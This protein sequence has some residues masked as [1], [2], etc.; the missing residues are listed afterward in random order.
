MKN[1]KAI[2]IFGNLIF[3]FENLIFKISFTIG[4]KA[5]TLNIGFSCWKNQFLDLKIGFSGLKNQFLDLKNQ[6][7]D[8]KIGFSNQKI[9]LLKI[10]FS[11]QLFQKHNFENPVFQ[12]IFFKIIILKTQFSKHFFSKTLDYTLFFCIFFLQN[13]R[14]D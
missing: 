11:K 9:I 7:L 12:N 13:E 3:W 6:F 4:N 2:F 8:L 1:E 5:K 14:A 10:Q